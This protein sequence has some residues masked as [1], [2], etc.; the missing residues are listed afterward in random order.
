MHVPPGR[1][2]VRE[3]SYLSEPYFARYF[4]QRYKQ[5]GRKYW[6]AFINNPYNAVGPENRG[7]AECIALY[8]NST[9]PLHHYLSS[10]Q[11]YVAAEMWYEGDYRCEPF[12]GIKRL[13]NNAIE[14]LQGKQ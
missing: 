7:I 2:F 12:S 9:V 1:V 6:Q 3:H 10:G 5:D 8:L 4:A 11:K 13:S 14:I